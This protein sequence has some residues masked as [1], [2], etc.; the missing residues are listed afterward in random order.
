MPS[1][2]DANTIWLLGVSYSRV[3]AKYNKS[4]FCG[5][6]FAST[7]G[8]RAF[9]HKG[10]FAYF[11]QCTRSLLRASPIPRPSFNP[12]HPQYRNP[13][14]LSSKTLIVCGYSLLSQGC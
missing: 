3:M 7:E 1:V 14:R 11:V 4:F 6:A 9:S 13:S 8:Q 12:Y 2:D 10:F 5:S